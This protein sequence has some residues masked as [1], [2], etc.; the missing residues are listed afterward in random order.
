MLPEFMA[1]VKKSILETSSSLFKK[2]KIVHE[3]VTCD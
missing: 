2:E 1:K 3:R